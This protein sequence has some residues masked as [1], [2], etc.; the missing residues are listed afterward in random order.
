MLS[1]A[2]GIGRTEIG[3]TKHDEQTNRYGVLDVSGVLKAD[4]GEHVGNGIDDPVAVP[5]GLGHEVGS[6]LPAPAR[7]GEAVGAGAAVAVD[8]RA[9]FAAGYRDRAQGDAYLLGLL[10]HVVGVVVPCESR[11]QVD[12]GGDQHLGLAQFHPDTWAR[13]R[14]AP[15]AD[16]RDPAEQGYATANWIAALRRTGSDPGGSGGWPHCWHVR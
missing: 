10:D 5:S 1:L 8:V 16:W 3:G 15:D 7:E 14:R 12:A 4:S 11:W 13:A 2:A 6:G 9:L